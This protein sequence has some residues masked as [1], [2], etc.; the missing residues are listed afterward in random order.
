MQHERSRAA[1]RVVGLRERY[2]ASIEHCSKGM[3]RV[4]GG[5]EL[6][7]FSKN[8]EKRRDNLLSLIESQMETESPEQEA[9][10]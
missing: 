2:N 9:E 1:P 5:A 6:G 4:R 7:S 8:I 10:G 3:R